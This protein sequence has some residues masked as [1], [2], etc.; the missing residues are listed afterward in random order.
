MKQK[1]V[2]LLLIISF[3]CIQCKKRDYYNKEKREAY[4]KA[5]Y[6]QDELK[7]E[8]PFYKQ[9]HVFKKLGYRFAPKIKKETILNIAKNNFNI[10][11]PKK[12]FQDNSYEAL[13]YFL[14][15]NIQDSLKQPIKALTNKCIWFN[16]DFVNKKSKYIDFMKQ[17]TLISNR[18]LSFT[19]I[20][21]SIDNE[22]YE[23]I[24]FKVNGIQKKW[25]LEKVG[26]ISNTFFTNFSELTTEFKTKKQFTYFGNGETQFV[27]DYATNE[28]QKAF[29]NQTGLTR[30]WLNNKTILFD[31]SNLKTK[32]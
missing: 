13:Y 18:E 1:I 17:M 26:Y 22:S 16:L 7:L 24:E 29:E 4:K 8:V 2:Y 10:E 12:Y 14:G 11:S 6:I 32:F 21:I 9:I 20:K 23:W 5:Q 19:E 3:T 31:E 27:I 30:E 25:K 15:Y 28:E